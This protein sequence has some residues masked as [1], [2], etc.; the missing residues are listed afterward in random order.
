MGADFL[1]RAKRSINAARDRDREFLVRETL[2]TRHPECAQYAGRARLC[3]GVELNKGDKVQV[4]LHDG[5][6]YA[7]RGLQVVAEFTSPQQRML[8]AVECI[9]GL[10]EGTVVARMG[11]INSVEIALCP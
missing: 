4:E 1:Q 7:S 10:L 5:K 9:G 3:E 2:F 11:L 8:D 6:L